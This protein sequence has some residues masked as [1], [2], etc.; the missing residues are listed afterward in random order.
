MTKDSL[1][2]LLDE[3]FAG[4]ALVATGHPIV[5]LAL[6]FIHNLAVNDATLTLLLTLF[7]QKGITITMTKS[8]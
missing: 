3:V 5:T 2:Q 1:K 4:L 8:Q 7:G 6:A